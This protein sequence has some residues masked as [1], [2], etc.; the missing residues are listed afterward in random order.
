MSQ[1]EF[2]GLFDLF[3]FDKYEAEVGF[4]DVEISQTTSPNEAST[5]INENRKR[6]RETPEKVGLPD[7]GSVDC[8]SKPNTD[9]LS[10]HAETSS[11]GLQGTSSDETN[12]DSNDDD[13]VYS[14]RPNKQARTGPAPCHTGSLQ[15]FAVDEHAYCIPGDQTFTHQPMRF[16]LPATDAQDTQPQPAPISFMP[17]MPL[18]VPQYPMPA[19]SISGSMSAVLEASTAL[20]LQTV[21]ATQYQPY[22]TGAQQTPTTQ[23]PQSDQ[24]ALGPGLY[25]M[26]APLHDFTI[27]APVQTGRQQQ[28]QP[29]R[30]YG[31]L[32]DAPDARLQAPDVDLLL[33]DIFC[34]YPRYTLRT[35]VMERIM[36]NGFDA[37][38]VAA[39]INYFR[40]T[41]VTT[42][43]VY[44]GSVKPALATLGLV[45]GLTAGMNLAALRQA[46]HLQPNSSLR[47]LDTDLPRRVASQDARRTVRLWDIGQH[48]VHWPRPHGRFWSPTVAAVKWCIDNGDLTSTGDDV[49]GHAAALGVVFPAAPEP[50]N[51]VNRDFEFL[52][53]VREHCRAHHSCPECN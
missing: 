36:S 41:N 23:A 32:N 2:A 11:P 4:A 43:S 12:P 22:L 21:G 48:I 42:N 20:Q 13:V 45:Q 53:W 52:A 29:L 1:P 31:R 28:R 25:P 50:L 3:D 44:N 16:V 14:S 6:M 9:T 8:T 7:H 39:A 26:P 19:P 37:G 17:T 33:S 40:G 5:E 10:Q 24:V 49:S 34:L 46:G 47:V 35:G 51:H 30:A 18:G 15:T 38:D 27:T